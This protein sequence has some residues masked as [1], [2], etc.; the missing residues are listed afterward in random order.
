[1]ASSAVID[2]DALIN[3]SNLNNIFPLFNK[4]PSLFQT[5][6]FPTEV[7]KEY[8]LGKDK[9]P[10]RQILLQKLN[11]EQGFYRFCTTYDSFVLMEVNRVKGIDKGEAE[12]YAQMRK[13]GAQLIISDDKR[14]IKALKEL[15]RSIIV[16]TTLHLISIMEVLKVLPDWG[17]IIKEVHKLRP[18]SSKDLR[19]AYVEIIQKYGIQVKKKE[20]SLK[21]S[22]K[23]IL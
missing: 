1:M 7:V 12:V 17:S 4:L 10:H 8:S 22:L 5:I 11:P 20:I 19:I 23:Y 21:C 14:F 15:D 16:Y 18:F 13:V 9:D 2:C 6:Y 3:F